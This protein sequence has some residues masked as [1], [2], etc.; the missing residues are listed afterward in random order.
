MRQMADDDDDGFTVLICIS[1]R[2][3]IG[4]A[5]FLEAYGDK[6]DEDTAAEIR[7]QI[8]RASIQSLTLEQEQK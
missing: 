8:K 1:R 6:S 3:A 4:I 7:S 2:K 5:A